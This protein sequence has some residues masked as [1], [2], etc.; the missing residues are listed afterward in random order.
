MSKYNVEKVSIFRIFCFPLRY[1]CNACPAFQSRTYA[2]YS[3]S[4]DRFTIKI[5]VTFEVMSCSSLEYL[6]ETL[7][8]YVHD[9]MLKD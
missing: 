5:H 8:V 3:R 7:D 1:C 4:S 9:I 6:K 2:V